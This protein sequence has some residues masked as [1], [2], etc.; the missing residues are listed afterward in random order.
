VCLDPEAVRDTATYEHPRQQPE[1]I[2]Y[3]IVGGRVAV[4][5]GHRTGELAGRAL[6]SS[7]G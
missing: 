6:R 5:D 4:D 3:V 2:P 1:G 7:R